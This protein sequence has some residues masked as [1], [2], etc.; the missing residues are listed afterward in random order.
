MP[1]ASDVATPRPDGDRF[2]LDVPPGW[3]QGRGAYGGLTVAALVRAIEARVNEPARKVRSVTV[4]LPA[5]LEVGPSTIGVDVLRV[6]NS[7]TTARATIEQ[8]GTIR[9][10]AVAIVAITRRGEGPAWSDLAPPETPSWRSLPALPTLATP[11]F[12]AHFEYRV[13]EGMPLSR[14]PARTVGW[15]R[16]HVRT[17][18]RDAAYLAAAIDAWWPAAL[19]RFEAMRPMATIAF[20]LDIL[21][22]CAGLDPESPLLY[23]GTAPYCG[24]GYFLET[25]ELWGED[26]RLIAINHQTFAIIK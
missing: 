22:D 25:R 4:E 20:T 26:G 1:S 15:I 14:G 10:H 7:V 19:V 11:E 17:G 21:D 16:P 18:A 9:G 24:D 12:A 3:R 6:G 2:T 8:A 13:V 23:R 5:P